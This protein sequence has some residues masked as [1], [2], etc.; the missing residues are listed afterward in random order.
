MQI[1]SIVLG[2]DHPIGPWK[3]PSDIE[4]VWLYNNDCSRKTISSIDT[5]DQTVTLGPPL[6]QLPP[7][8]PQSY[9]IGRPAKGQTCFLENAFEFLDSPGEWY[10]DRTSGTLYYYPL[11]GETMATSNFV[12]AVVQ[13]CLLDIEGTPAKPVRNLHF[14]GISV[15]H[16]DYPLP[17]DGYVGLFGCIQPAVQQLPIP[18]L[19]F[20]WI[21]A[22]VTFRFAT[23]CSFSDGSVAHCGGIGVGML[24]G[25][26]RITVKGNRI[27]DLG[28]G[29]VVA[30]AIRNRD[31]L[32]AQPSRLQSRIRQAIR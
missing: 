31:F 27:Y 8:L 23:D 21:P 3:N 16:V 18:A 5:T 12:A 13:N 4:V 10:L 28:G 9:L 7:S 6:L 29:G 25:C 19:T 24:S 26:S 22:A 15:E 11:P 14:Q 1:K 17:D 20:S 2:L 30:G 32:Q